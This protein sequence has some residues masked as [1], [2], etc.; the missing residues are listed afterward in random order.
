MRGMRLRVRRIVGG[1]L[2]CGVSALVEPVTLTVHLEDVNVVG[3]SI[4]QSARE[5]L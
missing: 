3:E 1:G 5:P 2:S 4:Q